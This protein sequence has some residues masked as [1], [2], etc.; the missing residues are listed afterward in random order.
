VWSGEEVERVLWRHLHITIVDK[1]K[2]R[3]KTLPKKDHVSLQPLMRIDLGYA[4]PVPVLDK[5]KKIPKARKERFINNR[6]SVPV[7][8]T[9]KFTLEISTNL[10]FLF[11]SIS[12]IFF[13]S[14]IYCH[15]ARHKIFWIKTGTGTY[16]R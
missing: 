10:S 2:Q 12:F 9:G 16:F 13:R 8:L 11:A 3:I 14:H 5:L 4:L 15:F 6:N 1:A 7:L